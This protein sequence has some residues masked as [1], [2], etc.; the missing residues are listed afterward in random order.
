M[1]YS[2][3]KF[4]KPVASGDTNIQIIDNSN[5]VTFTINPYAVVN[6][7]VNNNLVKV[8]LRSLKTITIPF[9]SIN[10]AKLA[11]PRIKQ[12]FDLVTQQPPL[13]I[14]KDVKSYFNGIIGGATASNNFFYQDAT[15]TASNITIGALWYD[16]TD[17]Q[18]YIYVQTGVWAAPLSEIGPTG[19]TGTSYSF[20]YQSTAPTGTGTSQ[21]T[22]GSFWY[23]DLGILYVYVEDPPGTYLWVTP[24]AEIGPTGP[25]GATGFGTASGLTFSSIDSHLIPA[26]GSTYDIGATAG[27]EWR[28]LYLSGNTIY[29][30]NSTIHS[31]GSIVVFDSILIG[32]STESGGV[33]L[34][35]SD[36]E[37]LF[38]EK[39]LLG[40]EF[41]NGLSIEGS[42]V[43]LGG[44]ISKSI[45]FN[46]VGNDAHFLQF[47][48]I[49]F[50]SSNFGITSA[51]VSISA[52]NLQIISQ[53]N[54]EL[55]SDSQLSISA[56][57]S[58]V[59]ISDNRGLVYASDYSASFTDRSLVDKEFVDSATASIWSYFGTS[60][61]NGT[62]G[63]SGTSG[64]NG[65]S[66]SSGTSPSS[67]LTLSGALT[68]NATASFNGT[69]VLA[70]TIEV[71][72]TSPGA[73]SSTV[74]YDFTTGLN[75]YH[76]SINTNYTANFINLPTIDNRVVTAIIV[77]N[78]GGTAYIPQAVKI[79][80]VSQTIKWAGGTASG[81]P[82]QIDIVGFTFIR[83]SGSWS[84]VLGQINT[85]G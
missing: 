83:S 71:I 45:S 46:G 64:A 68:V 74:V 82:N 11:L 2:W 8:S 49:S 54:L 4:I 47:E 9:S 14:Q 38:N 32:G 17:G 75:W 42:T 58:L 29:L 81:T 77:I 5:K 28:D 35:T 51:T 85:F 70:E 7:F 24:L 31:T 44:T 21:I 50:T 72:N 63:S 25:T 26:T 79:S 80:G 30:G 40:L 69:T 39:T 16:T 52:D 78:Q 6:V 76:S 1:N 84:Q 60:G 33:L 57:S 65:S 22:P 15:P 34:S 27:Y 10:E 56:S 18:L 19:A 12:A 23:D 67:D 41:T 73:T 36:N 43:S 59:T 55:Q 37:I 53:G 13:F 48:N 66:G 62:S 61:V 20:Y 3:D